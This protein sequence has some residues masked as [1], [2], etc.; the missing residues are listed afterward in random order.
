MN[1]PKDHDLE[2]SL[3]SALLHNPGEIPEAFAVDSEPELMDD[4]KNRELWRGIVE[5][6]NESR[7]IDPQT[8][9]SH[10]T[11]KG[12]L[13][14]QEAEA[15]MRRI[16]P[17]SETAGNVGGWTE[18]LADLKSRRQLLRSCTDAKKK[19][20]DMN[21]SMQEVRRELTDTMAETQTVDHPD[22]LGEVAASLRERLHSDDFDGVS[23]KLNTGIRELDEILNGLMWDDF[24]GILSRPGWGKTSM[25][26]QIILGMKILNP[27]AVMDV[28][29]T[30]MNSRRITYRFISQISGVPYNHVSDCLEDGEDVGKEFESKIDDALDIFEQWK[31][32]GS[33]RLYT[34][35]KSAEDISQLMRANAMK[36]ED[37]NYMG[38][39]ID[40][41][42][43]LTNTPT[44]SEKEAAIRE[45]KNIT[46]DADVPV[47][48]LVQLNRKPDTDKVPPRMSHAKGVGQI[49]Q[50]LDR[51]IIIDRPDERAKDL[52]ESQ[53]E[54][55]GIKLNEAVIEVAKNRESGEGRFT[56]Y[57][58]GDT[59]QFLD[60]RPF[61]KEGPPAAGRDPIGLSSSNG[62][63]DGKDPGADSVEDATEEDVE[64]FFND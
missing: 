34:G 37:R 63:S 11:N 19:A 61:G 38:G 48:L 47:F 9:V 40:N 3:L 55:L 62:E 13:A 43:R 12:Y 57:F 10:V 4:P 30:E 42:Q 58:H 45:L 21:T 8:V 28:F 18:M 32:E 20:Q 2:E 6:H 14:K 22:R 56:K 7:P 24:V 51:G 27:D 46:I 23:G 59:T 31:E 15:K 33:I 53:L 36:D 26:V 44:L 64:A 25:M 1:V 5:L 16:V 29:T 17:L 50:D 41:F 39:F 60:E 35:S 52:S 49:D 54:E